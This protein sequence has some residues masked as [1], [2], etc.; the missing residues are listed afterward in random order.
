MSTRPSRPEIYLPI[1]INRAAIA[2]LSYA[3]MEME[4]HGLT[5]PKLRT[6]HFLSANGPLRVG[7]LLTRTSLEA[8][9]M[10][11][12]LNELESARLVRRKKMA[13]DSRSFEIALTPAGTKLM[14]EL[15]PFLASVEELQL[16][17]I[18]RHDAD[19]LRSLLIT[20]FENMTRA[21]SESKEKGR[22]YARARI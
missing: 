19:R 1:L 18:D 10:S 13:D 7:E 8:P 11:R 12:I 9:T 16:E 6:L 2:T 21:R 20:V 15:A 4:R 22:K 17:G 3:S 5:V 14:S